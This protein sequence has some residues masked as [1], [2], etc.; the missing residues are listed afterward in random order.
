MERLHPQTDIEN[1]G[2]Y[3]CLLQCYIY[4]AGIQLDTLEYFKICLHA[5]NAGVMVSGVA[6]DCTVENASLFLEWLTGRHYLI[7]KKV[8]YTINN[9]KP[10]TPV[11]YAYTDNK[12][13]RH[14]HFVVVKDG[15]I[16]FDPLLNSN[17]VAKGRPESARIISIAR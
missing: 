17:S 8:I 15:V 12:G 14:E 11:K 10:P 1:I 7:S 16:V 3:S 9:I 13:I 2:K 4:C 6:G 5:V